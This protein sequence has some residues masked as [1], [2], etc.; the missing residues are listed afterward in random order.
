MA[1]GQLQAGTIHELELELACTDPG[2][3]ESRCFWRKSM[4]FCMPMWPSE[5]ENGRGTLAPQKPIS[6]T[7]GRRTNIG[8]AISFEHAYT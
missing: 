4:F 7:C 5:G 2:P 3:T 6:L 8:T 1:R